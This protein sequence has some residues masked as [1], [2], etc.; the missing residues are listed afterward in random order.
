MIESRVVAQLVWSLAQ[1]SLIDAK[2]NPVG[3]IATKPVDWDQ[4]DMELSSALDGRYLPF[5][6]AWFSNAAHSPAPGPDAIS[7]TK[8]DQ[9][10]CSDLHH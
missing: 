3:S 5:S 6:A 10:Q 8:G 1:A 2:L 7:Y 4:V 9:R